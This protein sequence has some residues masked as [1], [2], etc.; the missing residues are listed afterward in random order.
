[1][2]LYLQYGWYDTKFPGIDRID[3]LEEIPSSGK[4]ISAICVISPES[5]TTA[6]TNSNEI[7][8]WFKNVLNIFSIT[9]EE[10]RAAISNTI[11]EKRFKNVLIEDI[12]QRKILLRNL[13]NEHKIF[14]GRLILSIYFR[15]RLNVYI[16]EF[17]NQCKFSKESMNSRYMNFGL[18][19][20]QMNSDVFLSDSLV[21]ERARQEP[22]TSVYKTFL[23]LNSYQLKWR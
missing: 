23:A 12:L 5:D 4:I 17:K 21:K 8:A 20:L 1:M 18:R 10:V 15:N 11:D 3:F 16:K 6:F 2:P 9:K 19:L 13:E 14:L 22:V 7:D